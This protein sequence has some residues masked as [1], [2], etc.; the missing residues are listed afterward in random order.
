MEERQ[1]NV[2]WNLPVRSR[3]EAIETSEPP[4]RWGFNANA[5]TLSTTREMGLPVWVSRT[6]HPKFAFPP[7]SLANESKPLHHPAS[8]SGSLGL[9]DQDGLPQGA[10]KAFTA[11]DYTCGNWPLTWLLLDGSKHRLSWTTAYDMRTLKV[12]FLFPPLQVDLWP[13]GASPEP[14]CQTG[15]QSSPLISGR[16]SIWDPT[17][18]APPAGEHPLVCSA[19]LFKAS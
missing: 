6:P 19:P 5:L 3:K 15:R 2:T 10:L 13:S 12:F 16:S 9:K 4:Q 11:S 1:E 7:N 14:D 8:L 18:L 17:R